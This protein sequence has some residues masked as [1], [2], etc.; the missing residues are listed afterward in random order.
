MNTWVWVLTFTVL[1]AQ[2]EH[3]SFAKY[4]SEEE[5]LQAL[6]STREEYKSKNKK[7]AGSCKLVLSN[8]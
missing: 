3:R 5:C 2:P 6:Q 7:I 1:G 8:K 4:K